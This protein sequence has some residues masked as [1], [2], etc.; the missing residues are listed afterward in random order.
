MSQRIFL[1]P[2]SKGEVDLKKRYIVSIK[3]IIILV[4]INCI[5]HVSLWLG[6][7]GALLTHLLRDRAQKRFGANGTKA[8]PPKDPFSR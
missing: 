2:G 6:K 1:M 4:T 8:L 3:G 7:K 5:L